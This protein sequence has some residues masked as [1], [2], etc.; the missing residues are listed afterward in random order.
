MFYVI[1]LVCF[2][3]IIFFIMKTNKTESVDPNAIQDSTTLINCYVIKDNTLYRIRGRFCY[4]V[5]KMEISMVD[6]LANKSLIDSTNVA[7]HINDSVISSFLYIC[8]KCKY[9]DDCKSFCDGCK[10]GS[11]YE[12]V[13]K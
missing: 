7:V 9:F 2:L 3:L 8:N 12:E 1:F 10:D 4:P 5:E 6:Y 13:K 11:L